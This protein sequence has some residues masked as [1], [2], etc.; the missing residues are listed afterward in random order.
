MFEVEFH[1]RKKEIR[2]IMNIV[3]SMPNLIT[4]IYGPINS[5][6]TELINH[7]IKNLPPSYKAIYINLRGVYVNNA[8]DF[9]KVLFEV[10]GEDKTIK[11]FLKVVVESLPDSLA[12]IPIP[13]SV[14]SK[15]FE[16]KEMENVFR[17]L[18]MFFK[19]VSEKYVPVFIIDELQVIGDIEID[20][21][22]IYRLFNFFIRLTKELHVC[23][24]FAVTSDSLFIEKVYSEAMLQGRCR[25]LL[26]DDFD[27][28]T[29]AELLKRYEFSD[30]EIKLVWEYFG[31][32]PVY[33]IEAVRAKK[34]GEN[35]ND[36]LERFFK[37]R[38][39]QIKDTV[40]E[41]E[42]K[43]EELFSRVLTLFKEFEE[44]DEFEYEKLTAEIRFCIKNNILFADPVDGIVKPQSRLDLLAI[45]KLC[46]GFKSYKKY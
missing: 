38:L 37:I 15:F 9:L 14:F 30:D 16:E 29:T 43:N 19:S 42:E 33:L 3:G 5:G 21:K 27:Y 40:Y 36:L 10:D 12:G 8:D 4:F 35:L 34:S 11:E 25:Y 6:K 20:G 7:T 22:L 18:E 24:V 2:E 17:Y 39:R 45:R 23:H 46:E 26:V 1:D 41:L 32:K 13:K 31:G 44:K 28:E